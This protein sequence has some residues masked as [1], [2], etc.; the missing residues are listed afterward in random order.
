M[1][2]RLNIRAQFLLLLVLAVLVSDIV[3]TGYSLERIRALDL[4]RSSARFEGE[5][6]VLASRVSSSFLTLEHD[7]QLIPRTPPFQGLIRSHNNN[8]YDEQEYST[9]QMWVNRLQTIFISTLQERPYY[10]QL[11]YIG[12]ADGGRELVRVNQDNEGFYKVPYHQLQRKGE[13][14]YLQETQDLERDQIYLS[15]I[16]YNREQEQLDDDL[17]PT[18][19]AVVPIHEVN[20]ERFGTFVVNLNIEQMLKDILLEEQPAHDTY[21]YDDQGNI[22]WFE[23]A[24]GT[25]HFRTKEQSEEIRSRVAMA[26]SLIDSPNLALSDINRDEDLI[27]SNRISLGE[28]NG[29]LSLTLAQFL[30]AHLVLQEASAAER[31][32]LMT[33]VVKLGIF[34]VLAFAAATYFTRPILRLNEGVLKWGNG[35]T[36]LDLPSDRSDEVGE[37]ARSFKRVVTRLS[38]AR[39]SEQ[40]AFKKVSDAINFAV[41]GLITVS[42][43]GKIQSINPVACKMFATTEEISVGRSIMWILPEIADYLKSTREEAG[44]ITLTGITADK[45]EVPIELS[46]SEITASDGVFYWVVLRDVTER[47]LQ[48]ALLE[49]ALDSLKKTNGELN[50]FAYIASHDLR[51]PLRGIQIHS[52]SILKNLPENMDE[53]SQRK[54]TRVNE[55]AKRM[56]QLVTDLLEF[57]KLNKIESEGMTTDVAKTVNVVLDSL[58]SSLEASNAEIEIKGPLPVVRGETVHVTSVFQNLISNALKYND[59]DTPKITI[60]LLPFR[61]Y[62]DQIHSNVFYVQDNGIGIHPDFHNEVFKIFKR[63]N[64]EKAYGYGTGAGLTFVRKIVNRYGGTIWLESEPELGTTFYFT[65]KVIDHE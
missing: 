3:T 9:S 57:S 25:A 29:N 42:G 10:T 21:I 11:R 38:E 14:P 54:I 20:G 46:I 60:G 15:Q 56:Q 5:S 27:Y 17:V 33:S 65:F 30:P 53:D 24:T 1:P 64:N 40:E 63:L 51:E 22:A 52:Q 36:N 45:K 2:L 49:D 13:E 32:Y 37:L 43:S 47:M 12:D 23:V 18:L 48:Q 7:L 61:A 16:S 8:D 31:Q 39:K 41:D 62:Q 58:Q 44:T 19:R 35:D 55:L 34:L 59:S 6:A 4:A 26:D 28:L 50:D